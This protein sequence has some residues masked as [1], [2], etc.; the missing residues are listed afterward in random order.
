[1]T[2]F[3]GMKSLNMVKT[4][5]IINSICGKAAGVLYGILLVTASCGASLQAEA[6][7]GNVHRF[8]TYNVRYMN[9]DDNNADNFKSWHNRYRK[10]SALILKYDFD[11]IGMQ[12]ATGYNNGDAERINRA[13]GKSQLDDL[14]DALPGYTILSWEREGKSYQYNLIAF[15]KDR[16]GL[17][18][19]G[20]IGL[21]PSGALGGAGWDPEL[22]PIKRRAGWAKFRD[23]VTN[24]VF[25]FCV[26]H[27]NYGASLDGIYANR[28]L[29]ERL[30][31]IAGDYP[32]VL[33]GDF[34]M[35]RVDHEKAYRGVA[36]YFDD[37]RLIAGVNECW[38][39]ENG[40]TELT[41]V[42]W[43]TMADP[44]KLKG[45][46]FDY[47][48]TRNI[49]VSERHIL[50]DYYMYDGEPAIPSD[51]YPIL[52]LCT[53]RDPRSPQTWCVSPQG[54]DDADGSAQAPLRSVGEAVRKA[55]AGD[56][57]R[58]AAGTYGECVTIDK[59]L[60]VAGGYDN[61]FSSADGI[62]VFDAAGAGKSVFSVPQYFN[63]TLHDL[64]IRGFGNDAGD[65][66]AGAVRFRGNTL[67]LRNVTFENNRASRQGGALWASCNEIDARG[68]LFRA[69][70]AEE[71]GGAAWLDTWADARFERCL[72][73]GNSATEGA[74]VYMTSE[75]ADAKHIE[76][77]C[78]R[79]IFNC[80]SF[81][82][83][84]SARRGAVCL[85]GKLP[86]I[87]TV[88]VNTTMANNR[89]LYSPDGSGVIGSVGG[90]AVHATLLDK[91][92]HKCGN[93]T[94]EMAHCSV[95]ANGDTFQGDGPAD[96]AGGAVSVTGGTTRLINNLFLLNCTSAASGYADVTADSDITGS[97]NVFSGHGTISESI[98]EGNLEASAGDAGNLV[99]TIVADG[100]ELVVL[101]ACEGRVP[102][103]EL[104]TCMLGSA[105]LR[106]L[107]AAQR[108]VE[109]AFGLDLDGDG[110]TGAT[111]ASDQF[112]RERQA[113]SV[114]GALEYVGTE[115]D[116]GQPV[117]YREAFTLVRLA[118]N[119][120]LIGGGAVWRVFT[121][122]GRPV[123]TGDTPLI[124]LSDCPAGIY[125]VCTEH[126]SVKLAVR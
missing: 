66:G 45:S 2:E 60:T 94:L 71:S 105:D 50:T 120:F 117:A 92:A 18:G 90:S 46:E 29:G 1:M 63:L 118:D 58:L 14:K 52:T 89:L 6:A 104:K 82:G 30:S 125:I 41:A 107:D 67:R 123:K 114:P 116:L 111:L 97:H 11:I 16:Y 81:T 88:F 79:N 22:Y 40:Q 24:E 31:E 103:A 28:L 64:V 99:E 23:K 109:R 76:F 101:T 32:V 21:S 74:A 68:C 42:S 54:N 27:M 61:S 124:N 13:T 112:G 98:G 115:G 69:N 91:G 121:A 37:S 100:S 8:G 55:S 110:T 126:F 26:T 108:D 20:W 122:E 36:A 83:N 38:P 9:K 39:V 7:S 96:C 93:S 75:P 4:M 85:D 25:F 51:H 47:V 15:K 62:S 53:L 113:K 70:S 95:I 65:S 57:I 106:T 49:D 84:L 86:N 10:V 80:C 5:K 59:S 73:D 12:E 3:L 34:N 33:V 72:F 44:S 19:Q 56:E 48:F 78:A 43:R 17:L 35:R 77:T 102:G 87:R 119:R